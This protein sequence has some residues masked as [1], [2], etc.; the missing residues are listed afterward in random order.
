VLRY[1]RRARV[2]VPNVKIHAAI[3]AVVET[4]AAIGGRASRS[5]NLDK[6]PGRGTRST[7]GGSRCGICSGRSFL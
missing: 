4:Q 2:K 6:T 7:S 5:P 1:H 3:H